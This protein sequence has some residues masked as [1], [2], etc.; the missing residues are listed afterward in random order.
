MASSWIHDVAARHLQRGG[1]P[2]WL[3]TAA[4]VNAPMFDDRGGCYDF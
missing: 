1:G 4:T 3:K 2:E